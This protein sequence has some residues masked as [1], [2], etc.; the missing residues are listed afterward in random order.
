MTAAKTSKNR[1]K[2][3]KKKERIKSKGKEGEQDPKTSATKPTGTPIK[4]RRLVNGAEIVFKMPGHGS[5]S[6]EEDR[7][8]GAHSEAEVGPVDGPIQASDDEADTPV[9]SLPI[10][11]R[12]ITIIDSD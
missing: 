2:R 3:L 5:D 9:S 8:A 10:I 11:E 1:A 4:K 12:K 7:D 6:D